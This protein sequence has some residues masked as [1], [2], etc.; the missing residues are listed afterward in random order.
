ML[1]ATQQLSWNMENIEKQIIDFKDIHEIPR[2]L[3]KRAYNVYMSP[4]Y[5]EE[6]S[7]P[8][9]FLAD[10]IGKTGKKAQ[11]SFLICLKVS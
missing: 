2:Q 9:R 8:A 3:T 11:T 6:L 5:F 10:F 7:D 4:Y 1:R